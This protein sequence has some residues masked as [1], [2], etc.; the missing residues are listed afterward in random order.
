M[1]RSDAVAD[2]GDAF[3]PAVPNAVVEAGELD[4]APALVDGA[5]VLGRA[6]GWSAVDDESSLSSPAQPTQ[7]QRPARMPGTSDR[8]AHATSRPFVSSAYL[9]V[10]KALETH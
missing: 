2:R 1:N 9:P 7:R 5:A 10:A 3:T 4:A 6:P 8:P